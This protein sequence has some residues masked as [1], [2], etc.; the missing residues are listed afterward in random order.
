M[1]IIDEFN[2]LT[3]LK[4]V[5]VHTVDFYK[6]LDKNIK[7]NENL[8]FIVNIG[9][10]LLNIGTAQII[11]RYIEDIKHE[12]ESQIHIRIKD[13]LL[14]ISDLISSNKI[15]IDSFGGLIKVYDYKHILSRDFIILA[16]LV[17][18]FMS[19]NNISEINEIDEK[20]ILID[21]GKLSQYNRYSSLSAVLSIRNK[22]RSLDFDLATTTEEIYDEQYYLRSYHHH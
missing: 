14:K 9:D 6:N 18:N 10:D 5:D 12:E 17:H 19:K 11:K 3:D 4:N 8:I 2:T 13:E 7:Q 20:Q 1:P 21:W 22:L 16:Q 15:R